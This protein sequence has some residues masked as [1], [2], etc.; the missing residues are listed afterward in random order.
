MRALEVNP[1]AGYLFDDLGYR[2]AA[3]MATRRNKA[4]VEPKPLFFSTVVVESLGYSDEELRGILRPIPVVDRTTPRPFD[5]ARSL[6]VVTEGL[7]PSDGRGSEKQRKAVEAL[8]AD[9]QFPGKIGSKETIFLL[10]VV[11]VQALPWGTERREAA[12]IELRDSQGTEATKERVVTRLR[13]IASIQQQFPDSTHN[14]WCMALALARD[15]IGLDQCLSLA[16]ELSQPY[17]AVELLRR[18]LAPVLSGDA[19]QQ[20]E[21]RVAAFADKWIRSTDL[22]PDSVARLA[23]RLAERCRNDEL[24]RIAVKAS[25]QMRWWLNEHAEAAFR[26]IFTLRD[27][28]EQLELLKSTTYRFGE[29]ELI[30]LLAIHGFDQLEWG[31]ERLRTDSGAP[32]NHAPTLTRIHSP[33]LVPLMLEMTHAR[34]NATIR[35][36]AASAERWVLEEGANAVVPLVALAQRRGAAAN[37]ACKFLRAIYQRGGAEL[38]EPQLNALSEKEQTKIRALLQ[39]SSPSTDGAQQREWPTWLSNVKAAKGG[40]YTDGVSLPPLSLLSGAQLSAEQAADLVR[41]L[42]AITLDDAQRSELAA[43]FDSLHRESF[44]ALV[45]HLVEGFSKAGFAKAQ[46]WVLGIFAY[47]YTTRSLAAFYSL[48]AR[49]RRGSGDAAVASLSHMLQRLPDESFWIFGDL[50]DAQD[51]GAAGRRCHDAAKELLESFAVQR[52]TSV[53]AIVERA[54]PRFEGDDSGTIVVDLGSR[55]LALRIVD[56]QRLAISEVGGHPF[57]KFPP[58]KSTDDPVRYDIA[59]RS[60]LS[61]QTL[62]ERYFRYRARSLEMAMRQLTRWPLD[63]WVRRYTRHPIEAFFARSIVWAYEANNAGSMDARALVAYVRGTE[64]GSFVDDNN[65]EITLRE[66]G[67]LRVAHPIEMSEEQRARW[68]AQLDDY[69]VI[70]PFLQM[71]R[72][73]FTWSSDG[74]RAIVQRHVPWND[75]EGLAPSGWEVERLGER[76]IRRISSTIRVVVRFGDSVRTNPMGYPL[77]II[78][79]VLLVDE[80]GHAMDAPVLGL[81]DRILVSECL[82]ELATLVSRSSNS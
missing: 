54:V 71:V 77:S 59:K 56:A 53:E 16:V 6:E 74:L 81:V 26:A 19:G 7:H 52:T 39:L 12:W 34:G 49:Q 70:Q 1:I 8:F 38:I 63:V 18:G 4:P 21:E 55:Q 9:L 3:P 64:D 58:I 78:K 23:L 17:G 30:R 20:E 82:E 62:L 33:R 5:F 48:F 43:L 36:A 75:V 47:G 27:L 22:S 51:L 66:D 10:D 79:S 28:N 61:I 65:D 2:S 76:A 31:L 50:R 69:R 15:T 44:S 32:V 14:A 60:F 46:R 11:R 72:P 42:G 41:A 29:N 73:I 24:I 67:W 25:S 68:R 37:E 35:K 80:N 57:A 40:G 45:D 13:T